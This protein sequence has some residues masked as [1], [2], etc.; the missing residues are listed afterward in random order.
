MTLDCSMSF[1][2]K[3]SSQLHHA[4]VAAFPSA[5]FVPARTEKLKEKLQKQRVEVQ[6]SIPPSYLT[7]ATNSWTIMV[8][9]PGLLCM[10]HINNMKRT[11]VNNALCTWVV[12][13]DRRSNDSSCNTLDLFCSSNHLTAHCRFESIAPFSRRILGVD[14]SRRSCGWAPAFAQTK[15]AWL[16][17]ISTFISL[18]CFLLRLFVQSPQ[19]LPAFHEYKMNSTL[20][21]DP[22][23][24]TQAFFLQCCN[25][26][27][28]FEEWPIGR[29]EVT[30][31]HAD[32]S[33]STTKRNRKRFPKQKTLPTFY[34]FSNEKRRTTR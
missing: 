25:F 33:S 10:Q 6:V 17:S 7:T 5:S 4:T 31:T 1:L 9:Q 11:A 24:A 12:H 14:S 26:S 15:D 19:H 32:I 8:G 23:A 27:S 20:C 21:I 18:A 3:S 30:N 16:T 29:D 22:R 2:L 34:F 28:W 13:M